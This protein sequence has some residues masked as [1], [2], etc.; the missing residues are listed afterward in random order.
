M[1]SSDLQRLW[2]LADI[3]RQL[4]EVRKRAAA[5]DIGQTIQAEMEKFQSVVD[6]VDGKAKEMQREITDLELVQKGDEA[7]G[8][9]FEK[10]LFGGKVLSPK[11]AG[12]LEKEI[13]MLKRKSD[14]ESERL[15]ELYDLLPP[16]KA[17]AEEVRKKLDQ[18][19]TA[20]ADRRKKAAVERQ[21][22]EEAFKSLN[23][24]RPE[25]AKSVNPNLLAKYD[26]IRQRHSGIGMVAID[27]KTGNCEGC[28]THQPERTLNLLREDKPTVCE[29][30]HRILFD[31]E[32][33]I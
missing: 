2:K 9:K 10:E 33:V 29:S 22:L 6:E 20:L 27:K 23:A 13:Q 12:N 24:K 28:G 30:C 26:S 4:L 16:A 8:K 17:A 3:D 32:G 14:E 1:A 11:E 18:Y 7:K 15:L 19:K 5:L 31:L 25:A 21:Q